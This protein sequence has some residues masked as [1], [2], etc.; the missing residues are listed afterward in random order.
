MARKYDYTFK[1]AIKSNQN[2]YAKAQAII[3]L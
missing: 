3:A 1:L 2:N